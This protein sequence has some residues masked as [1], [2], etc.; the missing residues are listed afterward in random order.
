MNSEIT[1]TTGALRTTSHLQ[2]LANASQEHCAEKLA[3]S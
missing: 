2:V 1:I 3:N